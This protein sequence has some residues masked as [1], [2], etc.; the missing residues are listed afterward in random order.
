MVAEGLQGTAARTVAF[1]TPRPVRG[2]ELAEGGCCPPISSA[3]R[4][5][6]AGAPGEQAGPVDWGHGQDA[7]FCARLAHW[8]S[9]GNC[10]MGTAEEGP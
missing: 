1:T 9:F 7:F 5:G 4:Q 10:A 2:T 8:L 6:P 3:G